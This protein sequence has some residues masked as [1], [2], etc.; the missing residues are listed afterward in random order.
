MLFPYLKKRQNQN[1][2]LPNSGNIGN[3]ATGGSQGKRMWPNLSKVVLYPQRQTA[4][5]HFVIMGQMRFPWGDNLVF[6]P[7]QL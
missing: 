3:A 6:Y 7:P 4:H 5:R 2:R 1:T